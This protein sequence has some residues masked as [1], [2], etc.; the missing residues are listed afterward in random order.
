VTKYDAASEVRRGG[1]AFEKPSPP[2]SSHHRRAGD[3]LVE[4]HRHSHR[5]QHR[6]ALAFQQ[7]VAG[8]RSISAAPATPSTCS[9]L[10]IPAIAPLTAGF[11]SVH[12]M[13]TARRAQRCG[14]ADGAQRFHQTPVVFGKSC[15][16]VRHGA[17]PDAI[18]DVVLKGEWQ[19]RVLDLSRQ[20][21]IGWLQRS[22][23]RHF[24]SAICRALKFETPM[25]RILPS[26]LTFASSHSVSCWNAGRG[27]WEA[28]MWRRWRRA[29]VFA[30]C[31][32]RMWEIRVFPIWSAGASLQRLLASR[33]DAE[34]GWARS[35]GGSM[36]GSRRRSRRRE[37]IF[38]VT[39]PCRDNPPPHSNLNIHRPQSLMDYF[40]KEEG[41]ELW[42]R[43][44]VHYTR[45]PRRLAQ[46][47]RNRDRS[48]RPAMPRHP[49]AGSRGLEC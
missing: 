36:R 31:R 47:D 7:Q 15:N 25:L 40:G 32:W 28:T 48:F 22:D 1:S 20:P 14:A 45:N 46:S 41:T 42:N 34:Q 44:T 30:R 9:A 37:H 39:I 35:D 18:T 8:A 24:E 33:I 49:A 11:R 3:R 6:R 4:T 16:A 29:T 2:D 10:R 26:A 23:G 5:L 21:R 19:G 27:V 38:T 13:A 12:A 17:R 43:L